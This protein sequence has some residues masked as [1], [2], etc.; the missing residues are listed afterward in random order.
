MAGLFH[1]LQG[2]FPVK[3][4]LHS[5]S[6]QLEKLFVLHCAAESCQF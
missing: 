2:T 4:T 1:F 6:Q 5:T 3:F